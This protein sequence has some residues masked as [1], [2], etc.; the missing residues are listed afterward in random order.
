MLKT[1]PEKKGKFTDRVR[2]RRGSRGVIQP[3]PKEDAARK[4]DGKKERKP[5]HNNKGW[6]QP[7][8]QVR[9]RINNGGF[10][11]SCE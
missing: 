7:H 2:Y 6:G 9:I 10:G 5:H 8:R 3:E 11:G 1:A 4:A